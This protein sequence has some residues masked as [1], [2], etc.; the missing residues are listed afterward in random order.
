MDEMR[1]RFDNR[2]GQIPF[3]RYP[4]RSGTFLRISDRRELTAKA[5]DA[6]PNKIYF[7]DIDP[8]VI[9]FG[10]IFLVHPRDIHRNRPYEPP[11]ARAYAF[12]SYPCSL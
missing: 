7:M 3:P 4:H 6:T 2:Q 12:L 5:Q 1:F 10:L 11:G 8:T 9:S